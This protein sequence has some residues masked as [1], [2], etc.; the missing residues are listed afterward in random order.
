M[1]RVRE[2]RLATELKGNF[3]RPGHSYILICRDALEPGTLPAW[4]TPVANGTAGIHAY[5]V[6]V[7]A[8]AGTSTLE[9]LRFLGVGV[10]ADVAIRPAGMVPAA[11]DGEGAA[12]WTGHRRDA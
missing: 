3:V 10:Q 5:R 8:P 6:E 11:W 1:F 2:P 12:E 4:V 9:T 7:P